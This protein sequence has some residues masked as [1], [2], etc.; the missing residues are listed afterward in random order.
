MPHAV[1]PP[2]VDP[3]KSFRDW[4]DDLFRDGYVV[5]KNVIPQERCDY[6]IDKMFE[7]AGRFPWGFDRNDRSTWTDEHLPTHIKGGMYHGY[8][9]QHERFMWEARTEPGVIEAFTKLWGTDKLLA[10]FDGMNFTLPSGTPLEP[11]QPWPHVDQN[12][13]RTGMQ[14]VQGIINLAPNGPD[15]GGLLV[16]Q[17]S[18]K[19][20]EEFFKTHQ[21]VIGRATWGSSDWF[22]F[23][24]EEVKWF[25][26]RGCKILKVCAE[27]GSIILWDSRTM[28]YNCVPKTQNLR[29]VIYACYTPSSFASPEVLK[30]KARFFDERM[31]T[32]HWPH[33]NLFPNVEKKPR[34]G[35]PDDQERDRPF[36][37]P[38]E[39]ELV[40]KLAGKLPY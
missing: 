2:T 22:G 11:T 9:V 25:E 26:D 6:Y 39:T 8:R 5:I 31:G 24:E 18:T 3:T 32:T 40:L 33:D 4:R 29:A 21:G 17:G 1:E 38:E 27:P 36:E 14:C 37:E 13:K 30:E 12:P 10:S 7:W 23:D 28:H 19:I 15:D 16:M 34:L 35:L 20:M